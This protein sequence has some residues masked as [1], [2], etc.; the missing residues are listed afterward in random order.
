LLVGLVSSVVTGETLLKNSGEWPVAGGQLRVARSEDQ[1]RSCIR[2]W[3][4]AIFSPL[5]TR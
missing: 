1:D 2:L 5:V 3:V 4:L